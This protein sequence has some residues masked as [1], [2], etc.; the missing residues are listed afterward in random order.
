MLNIEQLFELGQQELH[1]LYLSLESTIQTS[2]GLLGRKGN[3]E[4]T[5]K[6]EI[7]RSVFETIVEEA[8]N[9]S[10]LADNKRMKQILLE[11]A[12]Q[13]EVEELTSGKSAKQLKQMARK[14]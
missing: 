2:K 8:E 4:T 3:T 1:N 7:V 12:N 5:E 10:T 13:K 6:M 9:A 14:L 11:A